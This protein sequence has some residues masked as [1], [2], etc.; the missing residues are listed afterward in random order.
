VVAVLILK[1]TADILLVGNRFL[2][3][4]DER[5][6]TIGRVPRMEVPLMMLNLCVGLVTGLVVSTGK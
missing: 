4:T 2:T 6:P 3:L 1:T 5:V